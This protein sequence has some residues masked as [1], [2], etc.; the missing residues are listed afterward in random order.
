MTKPHIKQG[1]STAVPHYLLMD[2]VTGWTNGCDLVSKDDARR[3][4]NEHQRSYPR[5]RWALIEMI[6]AP[7]D[8]ADIEPF[9]WRSGYDALLEKLK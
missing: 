2:L 3:Q 5:G 7:A 9:W 8:A 4:Q 1:N 6:N